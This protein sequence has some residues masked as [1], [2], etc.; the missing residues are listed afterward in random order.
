MAREIRKVEQHPKSRRRQQPSAGNRMM[1]FIIGLLMFLIFAGAAGGYIYEKKYAPTKELADQAAYFGVSGD[2]VTIYLDEEQQ[3]DSNGKLVLAKCVNGGVFL[4]YEWVM[5]NLNRRFFWASDVNQV[6]YTM[7]TET[8]KYGIGDTLSDG[9]TPFLKVGNGTDNLY[10]NVKF[11][12]EHTNIRFTSYV[13]DEQ[14]RIFIFDDFAAYTEATVQK[15]EAVRLLGGVKSPVLTTLEQGANVKVLEAMENW[16]RVETEDGYIG[17]LR[18]KRL[19]DER[20]VTPESS[21]TAPEYTHKTLD[22]KVVMGFHQVTTQAANAGFASVTAQAAGTMNVIAPTWFI[23]NSDQGT[24]DSYWSADYVQ[25][26]HAAGYQV[27]ATVNN[28]D[29]GSIDESGFLE[30]TALREQLVAA[31]VSTALAGGI[32]GLNIDFELIPTGLGRADIQ[33]MRELGVACRQA[34]LVLSADCYVPYNYNSHY[35]IEELGDCIDY[36]VIMCYDEHYAGGEEGSVSSIDY[37]KR[38]ISEA[39]SA[40]DSRRVIIALPFYTRVWITGPDG[41]TRSEALS[42]QTA[43][44]WIVQKGVTLEWQDDLGQNFGEITDGDEV[45]KIW[46][47]DDQSMQLKVDAV[48]QADCG[49]VAAWKL[50]QEPQSF[51]SILNLNAEGTTQN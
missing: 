16:S 4:P 41:K 40:M 43:Q 37:V 35:D 36:V 51:W 19:G 39:S 18:N 49:G 10:L 50:G 6:L 2:E 47:E 33:F 17:W 26:A 15:T 38:G 20:S 5:S 14:K 31:L 24:F 30:N 25:A 46:M 3:E 11:V 42:V 1:P 13:A 44:N 22:Q 29:A 34:G 32:D 27:W 12:A 23:L 21:Y 48:K 7:P 9:S 45:K 8:L 28:F